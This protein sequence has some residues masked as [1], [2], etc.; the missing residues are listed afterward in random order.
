MQFGMNANAPG[1]PAITGRRETVVWDFLSL[2]PPGTA[3]SF[4]KFP[5]L[6]LG[7]LGHEVE[8]MV[9]VPN[10]VNR[11]MRRNLV[12]LREDGFEA[13]VARVVKNLKPLLQRHPGAT[14]RFRGL[15][16]RY[17]TQ[18][19]VPFIDARIDF[20]MRTAIPSSGTP[21]LQPRWLSAAYNAFVD[22][23]GS[24]YQIQMGVLFPYDRCPELR[25]TRANDMVAAAWL[26]CKPLVDLAR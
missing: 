9:T 25:Q 7:V 8:A 11:T 24:N 1:R 10:A 23:Q 20:D 3:G 17:R 14:P 6:T 21:K 2:V 26:A 16:R 18:R 15:Q 12:K 13:L 22:K 5:H 4:T 19:S